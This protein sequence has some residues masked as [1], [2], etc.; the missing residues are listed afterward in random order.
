M[1]GQQLEYVQWH[2]QGSV[3]KAELFFF[4]LPLLK[5][6]NKQVQKSFASCRLAHSPVQ[7]RPEENICIIMQPTRV[8]K[9]GQKKRSWDKMQG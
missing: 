8:K 7:I 6:K 9:K 2:Q 1:K 4:G 3:Q 5:G